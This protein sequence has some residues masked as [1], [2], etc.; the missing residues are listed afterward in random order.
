MTEPAKHEAIVASG[1]TKWFG[2]G[3]TRMT[4]V[5]GVEFVAHFGEMLF[6]VG[7]S[8]SGKT[9][10]LSMISGIL[11]PNSGTVTVNQADIWTLDNDHL[12]DFRLNTIGFVFQDFHLFP[13]L[14]SAENVAIPLILKQRDWDDSLAEARKCL[15]IVGLKE[16]AEIL[17]VKLSGG[18]QQRVAI[19]RAIVGS[20]QILILDEPTASLD[21]DTGKMIISFV[22]EKVLNKDRC[23]VIVTHDARINEYADRIIHMEDGRITGLDKGTE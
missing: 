18:E 8:G 15:E 10:L 17:P 12:A 4:A 23:I 9:T 3:P 11:R 19:A 7:P 21:G 5:N 6:I 13:R 20:P 22:K 16:R 14:T 1:L 2:D